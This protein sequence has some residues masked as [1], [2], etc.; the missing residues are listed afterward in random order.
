V[1]VF[2]DTNADNH[3]TGADEAI[4]LTGRSLTDLSTGNFI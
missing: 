4:I 1:V 2:I 3:I